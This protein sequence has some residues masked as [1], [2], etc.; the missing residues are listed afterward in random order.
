MKLSC[1]WWCW[2]SLAW[3]PVRSPHP[4]ASPGVPS[5]P[6]PWSS[7]PP[8]MFGLAASQKCNQARCNHSGRLHRRG[9]EE[10]PPPPLSPQHL[11]LHLVLAICQENIPDLLT[12][13]AYYNAYTF[14]A[15]SLPHILPRTQA[16]V[17]LY[18]THTLHYILP[19]F[20]F[21]CC[22]LPVLSLHAIS[23]SAMQNCMQSH[24]KL[25]METNNQNNLMLSRT[26]AI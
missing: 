20:P 23:C 6:S 24:A 10:F 7:L 1:F 19:N 21:P 5:S 18:T 14:L 17:L 22:I 9:Q 2:R 25:S 4:K 3:H 11:Q 13:V 26:T 15:V 8:I 16:V 12:Y